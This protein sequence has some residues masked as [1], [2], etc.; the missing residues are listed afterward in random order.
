MPGEFLDSHQEFF[1]VCVCVSNYGPS[2]K[3]LLIIY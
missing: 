2:F 3:Q 1:C